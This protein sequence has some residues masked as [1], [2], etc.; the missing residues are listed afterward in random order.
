MEIVGLNGSS[1]DNDGDNGDTPYDPDNVYTF[2]PTEMGMLD[3]SFN[4]KEYHQ[5]TININYSNNTTETLTTIATPFNNITKGVVGIVLFNS[6]TYEEIFGLYNK[7][8]F[9]DVDGEVMCVENKSIYMLSTTNIDKTIISATIDFNNTVDY[10]DREGAIFLGGIYVPWS[11]L[12]SILDSNSITNT[13]ITDTAFHGSAVVRVNMPKTVTNICSGAFQ[14]CEVLTEITLPEGITSIGEKTFYGCDMLENITIPDS[15]TTIGN[16]AFGYCGFKTI[17]L[18]EG[19]TSIGRGAFSY[20]PY[21]TS[22]TYKGTMEQW[23][24][25]SKYNKDINWN[26]NALITQIVCSDGT[27]TL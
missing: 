10:S 23:N 26:A 19:I 5:Y 13:A 16:Y 15:V 21:L 4:L 8:G 17:T 14:T 22:I 2:T 24:A 25:I 1:G 12:N 20:C 9:S 6:D 3:R 11:E 7:L 27:I 18:P